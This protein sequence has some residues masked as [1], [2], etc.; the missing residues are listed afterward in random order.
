M[1]RRPVK[2]NIKVVGAVVLSDGKVL[3]VQRGPTG[4]LP[5]LWE[6]PGGK[7]E[8]GESPREALAR[9]IDEELRCQVTVGDEI[10]TTIHEYDFGVVHL[11]TFYCELGHGA[12]QLTE[13]SSMLWATPDDL[14]TVEWAPADIP[15]VAL[16][17]ERLR[18]IGAPS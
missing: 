13:H 5:G 9:E 7:I 6:F 10:T 3:C 14:R 4:S 8:R 12:P 18:T 1:S 17:E 15:A 11:T 16:I 2:K